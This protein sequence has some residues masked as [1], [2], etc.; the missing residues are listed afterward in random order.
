MERQ[1]IVDDSFH[2]KLRKQKRTVSCAF[3][4]LGELLV[5]NAVLYMFYAV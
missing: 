4:I 1:W 2:V 3:V 5:R